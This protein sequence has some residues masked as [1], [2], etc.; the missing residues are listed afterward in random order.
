MEAKE[1]IEKLFEMKLKPK[2]NLEKLREKKIEVKNA[3]KSN[4]I[5]ADAT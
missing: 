5:H 1:E 3:S 4:K 2:V